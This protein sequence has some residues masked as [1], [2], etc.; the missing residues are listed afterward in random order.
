MVDTRRFFL[1]QTERSKLKSEIVSNYLSGWAN[2]MSS[3]SVE[4]IVY[5][6][7]MSGPGVYADGNRSTP[8]LVLDKAINHSNEKVREKLL[9]V[10]NDADSINIMRLKN[11]LQTYNGL[12][13]LNHRPITYQEQIDGGFLNKLKSS[14]KLPMLSFIDPFGYKGLSLELVRQ[15]VRGW[16]CDCIFFFNYRRINPG[17]E[18]PSLQGPISLLFTE[19]VLRELQSSVSRKSPRER[20]FIILEKVR[21]VFCGW[22]MKYVISFNFRGKTGRS[23]THCLVFVTKHPRGISIMKEVMAKQST[24]CYQGVP[25]FEYNPIDRN[26]C[27]PLFVPKPLDE[28]KMFLCNH[29]EGKSIGAG[30][31]FEFC[32]DKPYI[33]KNI[34]TALLELEDEGAIL[35]NRTECGARKGSFPKHIMVKFLSNEKRKLNGNKD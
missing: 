18:N 25:S 29:F 10:F 19:D 2:V 12:S 24:S 11:E 1:R 35:T 20:E 30:K 28:L 7:L 26:S 5:L 14:T 21:E 22:G 6:D 3:Q 8:L 23:L 27:L 32:L 13:R 16:G 15:L 31:I 34:R 33:E 4:K 17:I 9:I